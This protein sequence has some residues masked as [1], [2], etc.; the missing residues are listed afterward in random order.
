MASV[1]LDG[2]NLVFE[3]SIAGYD[4]SVT[5]TKKDDNVATGRLMNMFDV[6]ATR[7]K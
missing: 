5:L 3:F 7:K 6:I 4:V 2:E 1:K